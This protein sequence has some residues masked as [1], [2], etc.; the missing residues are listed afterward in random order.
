MSRL[1]PLQI[2]KPAEPEP[3]PDVSYEHRQRQHILSR[4]WSAVDVSADRRA[5]F[6]SVLGWFR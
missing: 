3:E 2:V 5:P 1:S 6:A 4:D